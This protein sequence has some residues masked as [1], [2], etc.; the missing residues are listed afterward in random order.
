MKTKTQLF[1]FLSLSIL[2]VPFI[3]WNI[4]FGFYAGYVLLLI[5]LAGTYFFRKSSKLK[6]VM[7]SLAAGFIVYLLMVP[8]T[9]KQLADTSGEYQAKINREG[10]LDFIEKCNIY[11][12]N[13]VMNAVAYPVFPELSKEA[14]LMMFPSETGVRKFEG[15]FFM[16]SKMMQDAFKRSHRGK[17]YWPH[18][19]FP[20]HEARTGLTLN[21]CYYEIT[22]NNG[23]RTYKASTKVRYPADARLI[24]INRPLKVIVEEGTF[25]YLEKIGW[26]HPYTAVWTYKEK[27]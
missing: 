5:Y 3:I 25:H 15:G 26:L 21:L 10:H 8:L 22:E 9:L 14:F 6:P 24:I 20:Y 17:V 4:T 19:D 11:G 18:Y 12:L 23:T 27:I 2:I 7:L 1:I 13:I 16:K